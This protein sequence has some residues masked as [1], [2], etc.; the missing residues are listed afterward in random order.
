MSDPDRLESFISSIGERVRLDGYALIRVGETLDVIKSYK[1][2]ELQVPEDEERVFLGAILTKLPESIEA[3]VSNINLGGKSLCLFTVE[4]VSK[5]YLYVYD[6]ESKTLG[7]A[8]SSSK[9]DEMN[10]SLLVTPKKMGPE[11]TAQVGLD[12][13]LKKTLEDVVKVG[14]QQKK[15]ILWLKKLTDAM[16]KLSEKIAV[17]KD[18]IEKRK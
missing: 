17:L 10:R 4:G 12:P 5:N 15:M 6:T 16:D 9:F 2:K 18:I 14:E 8:V 7:V 1:I 13:E 11:K 3:I